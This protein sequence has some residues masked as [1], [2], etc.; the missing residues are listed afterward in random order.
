VTLEAL[1]LPGVDAGVW[2]RRGRRDPAACALADRHYSRQVV[3]CGQVGG[4]SR[5]L[6]LVTPCE[7]A[8]WLTAWSKCPDDGL[9][10]YRCTMFRNEGAGLSST[11]IRAAVELTVDLWGPPPPDGWVTWVDRAKIAPTNR[12]GGCFLHA[13]WHLDPDWVPDR[14]RPSIVRLRL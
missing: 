2:Q 5:L 14:R 13:G 7:R 12:P 8:A 6:V 9:D 4:A 10:A 11:L 1:T 3:G